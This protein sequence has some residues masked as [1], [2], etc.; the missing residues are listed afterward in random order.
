MFRFL[1]G[2]VV[3]VLVGVMVIAPNPDLSRQVHD[4]WDEG[5]RWVTG[6]VATVEERVD[7]TRDA[8]TETPP[9]QQQ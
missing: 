4:A 6:F 1:L 5:R 3:G 9:A 7:E 8:E 2:V